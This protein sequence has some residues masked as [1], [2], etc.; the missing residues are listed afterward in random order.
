MG[1]P[2]NKLHLYI[3]DDVVENAEQDAFGHLHVADAIVQSI[4][5]TAPPFII[6]I[7]GGWGTGKSSILNLVNNELE[8]N[9][10][11]TVFIDAWRYSSADDLKRAFLVRIASVLA[12]NLLAELRARLYTTEQEKIAPRPSSSEEPLNERLVKGVKKL[13]NY[14]VRV[15]F[16]F[17]LSSILFLGLLAVVFALRSVLS[18]DPKH[19]FSF[20][21]VLNSFIEL[22]F[23]PF[24]LALV[25]QLEPLISQEPIVVQHERIDADELFAEYFDK[26]VNKAV[27]RLICS[28]RRLVIFV[29]NLDRLS[30]EKM[31]L[32]LEALKTYLGNTS[33]VFVVACDDH[34]VRSVVERSELVPGVDKKLG[35]NATK[36]QLGE[37][38]LDKFFQQTF[39]LPA[40]MEVDLSDFAEN[41][42]SRTQLHSELDQRGVNIGYLVSTI[43]PSDAS[44]PRKVKRLLNEFIAAYEVARRRESEKGGKLRPGALTSDPEFLGKFS[45]IRA[46]FPEFYTE[47][48]AR[49]S[50]LRTLTTE[51]RAQKD[52]AARESITK[53]GPHSKP[54]SLLGYLRKTQHVE[55][56]DIDPYIWISQDHL[57]IGL[58]ADQAVDLRIALSDGDFGKVTEMLESADDEDEKSLLARVAMRYVGQR[59]RGLN[60]QNGTLVLCRIIDQL[61]PSD[62]AEVAQVAANLIPRFPPRGFE[63]PDI[64]LVLQKAGRSDK[65]ELVNGLL[66]RLEEE[67]LRQETFEG[68][69]Q[70]ADVIEE[71]GATPLVQDWLGRRFEPEE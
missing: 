48:V 67:D 66:K 33:C 46:E 38:Y 29:D 63:A 32:A 65:R 15:F 52:D 24:I 16:A 45:T 55:V 21:E 44:S 5:N 34:V 60:Q 42:F 7:F 59:L 22:A 39:R 69:L 17:L 68:M 62:Q 4:L 57:S 50:L 47:L 14:S 53:S 56:S 28:N 61:N 27:S 18:T 35:S 23:V 58:A 71:A 20:V 49:P 41:E 12:P 2:Q 51:I 9:E 8:K 31:V 40:Y 11:V 54:E 19:D 1:N 26:V 30:D 43:L 70:Y 25:G 3:P 10:V 36:R 6:G 64:L 37:D 13:F